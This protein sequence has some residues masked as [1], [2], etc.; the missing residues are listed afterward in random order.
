MKRRFPQ[1]KVVSIEKPYI[2]DKLGRNSE[3]GGQRLFGR[4]QRFFGG[5]YCGY[6][7]YPGNLSAHQS[8]TIEVNGDRKGKEENI[9]LYQQFPH[10]AIGFHSESI[11]S[12][13]VSKA[14]P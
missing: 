12:D 3:Q 11:S 13:E 2:L 1:V 4:D 14:A 9:Q 7:L 6:G 8:E 10:V 5:K